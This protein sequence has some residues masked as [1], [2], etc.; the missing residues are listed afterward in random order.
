MTG[1]RWLREAVKGWCR[2]KGG[3]RGG[4]GSKGGVGFHTTCSNGLVEEGTHNTTGE[5]SKSA[6][7]EKVGRLDRSRKMEPNQGMGS[8]REKDRLTLSPINAKSKKNSD[9]EKSSLKEGGGGRWRGRGGGGRGVKTGSR[10][11]KSKVKKL[12]TK[13]KFK[14]D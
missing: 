1:G 14:K 3:E 6:G 8:Q 9:P 13:Q 2:K 10:A 4:S 5:G 11:L 7:Q 12:I